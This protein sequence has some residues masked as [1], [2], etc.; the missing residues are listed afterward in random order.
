MIEWNPLCV[1]LYQYLMPEGELVLQKVQE[2]PYRKMYLLSLALTNLLSVR[3]D[4][5][6][7]MFPQYCLQVVIWLCRYLINYTSILSFVNYVPLMYLRSK[8][9]IKNSVFDFKLLKS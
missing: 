6:T 1:E 5:Q 2:V 8:W 4:F 9:S 3:Y 7:K